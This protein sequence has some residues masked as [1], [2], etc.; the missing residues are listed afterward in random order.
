[1]EQKKEIEVF[2]T[3]A[4]TEKVSTIDHKVVSGSLVFEALKP[5]PGYYHEIPFDIKPVYLYLALEENYPLDKVIRASQKIEP[6]FA[7]KFD[8]GKGFLKVANDQYNVLRVRHL[9]NYDLIEK[10]QLSFYENGIRYLQK[11][12]KNFEAEAF[13]EIVKFLSLKLLDEDIWIDT[14]EDFHGYIEIPRKLDWNKFREVSLSVKYN[15]DGSKFDAASGAFYYQGKLH[16][17]VRI[18]SNK[19]TT[20][21]LKDLRKLYLEKLK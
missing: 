8:A 14:R 12:K 7:G 16:E 13:I 2:G 21:Y 10:L 20:A 19:I 17:F 3:L 18:Y 11:Q 4:K 5:F 1:M 9:N 6:A 15:W